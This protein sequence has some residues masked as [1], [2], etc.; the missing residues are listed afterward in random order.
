M[1]TR[2]EIL[3]GLVLGAIGLPACQ[4]GAVVGGAPLATGQIGVAAIATDAYYAYWT[5]ANGEVRRV[6]L[7][8]GSVQTLAAGRAGPSSIALDDAY[9]YWTAGDGTVARVPKKGGDV[10]VIAV[11]TAVHDLAVD[12]VNVYFFAGATLLAVPKDASIS[13][14]PTTLADG[15]SSARSLLLRGGL[16][17]ASE[18]D[19]KQ[20]NGAVSQVSTK[21][22]APVALVSQITPHVLT[23]SDRHLAWTEV[24]QGL[25]RI[26]G[27]DGADV[28]DVATVDPT[29][30]NDR[31]GNP[32]L[33]DA[34]VA[35][36]DHAFFSTTQ[37]IVRAV[38]LTGGGAA[39]EVVVEGAVGAVRLALDATTLYVA[40][41][42]DGAILA[43]PRA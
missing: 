30:V 39:P 17:W 4:S 32:E 24:G 13:T 15:Q 10:D 11:A 35:D 18:G 22:G 42:Q 27:I 14:P 21:G 1:I 23:A 8:G 33:L 41:A 12:D 29:I 9:V 2:R 43:L 34:L 31:T 3:G 19:D 5:L 28:V 26:A 7:D 36:A 16:V 25:V 40:N 6:S 38:P 20:S 37:G